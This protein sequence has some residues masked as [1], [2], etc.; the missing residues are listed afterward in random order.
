M[1]TYLLEQ[2][3]F[4]NGENTK[5]WL[6]CEVITP[7]A[8]GNAK[9]Y[10]H[11]RKQLGRFLKTKYSLTILPSNHTFG[12]LSQKNENLYLQNPVHDCS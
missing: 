11:V 9:W 12:H 2:L 3:K 8:D 1:T 5:C 6:R 4:K 7:F 10:S